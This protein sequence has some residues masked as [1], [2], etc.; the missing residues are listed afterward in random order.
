VL[1]LLVPAEAAARFNVEAAAGLALA[2][3]QPHASPRA[4]DSG[5]DLRIAAGGRAASP[6]VLLPASAVDSP[7]AWKQALAEQQ[8]AAAAGA[9]A[10]TLPSPASCKA[11]AATA[12]AAAGAAERAQAPSF[13]FSPAPK[14]SVLAAEQAQLGVRVVQQRRRSLLGRLFCAAA[15]IV[16]P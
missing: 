8:Y 2:L 12:A 5:A 14:G 11:S 4:G 7:Q 9:A 15:P 3:A 13:S 16:R 10:S 6:V 1:P